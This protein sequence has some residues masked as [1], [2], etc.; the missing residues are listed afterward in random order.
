MLVALPTNMYKN[1]TNAMTYLVRNSTTTYT[2]V[3]LV[4][5]Y[6]LDACEYHNNQNFAKDKTL[7]MPEVKMVKQ[8]PPNVPKKKSQETTKV[9]KGSK[10]KKTSG[11]SPN[12]LK[13]HSSLIL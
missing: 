13:I 2:K 4:R 10:S 8:R 6:V 7:I 5:K 11:E 1:G 12:V 3:N 9:T